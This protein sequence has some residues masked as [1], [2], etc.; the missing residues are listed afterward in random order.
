MEYDA[1]RVGTTYGDVVGFELIGAPQ[2]SPSNT[3]YEGVSLTISQNAGIN[4]GAV[5]MSFQW[6]SN[7][8]PIVDATNST[9]VFANPTPDYTANYSVTVSNFYGGPVTSPE[10]LITVLPGVKPFFVQ[11]PQPLSL[12]RYVGA[13]S[14]QLTV[15]A[16]GTPPFTYQ[17]QHAGT[18]IQSATTTAD[19]SNTLTISPITLA[20]AGNY[21]VTITNAYGSTNSTLAALNLIVP[22]VGSYAA[23]LLSL[24][25]NPTNLF[26]YWRMD[27]NATTNDPTLNEYWNGN[28]GMMSIQDLYN[29]RITP[30]EAAAPYIGFPSPHLGTALGTHGE[31]WDKPY[32]VDLKNLPSAQTNMTFTMWVKGGVRL[33]ARAGYGQA[34]GLENNGTSVRVLWGAY[35][36]TNGVKTATWDTGLTA[37]ADDWSFVALVVKGNDVTV[38][39]GGTNSFTSVS[40]ADINGIPDL[41]N[42]GFMTLVNS[43]AIGDSNLRLGVGRTPVPWADDGNGAPWTSAGGTWSDIAVFYQVLTAEQIKGLYLAGGAGRWLE[44]IPDGSGNLTLN[45]TSGF[46]LQEAAAVT[47]PWTD[48]VDATPPYSAPITT[49]GAKFYRV[50][51]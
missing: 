1:I 6:L 12:N 17:W 41:E 27:D 33:A 4:S 24:P 18:N 38:Y 25:T 7:G 31:L 43:T 2:G 19:V 36:S 37:S 8:V 30:G 3:V 22:A 14:A 45:W 39:V 10:T 9:L 51:P 44:G 21:S 48:I 23:A 49:T 26:G 28:S 34:Y 15:V 50:K 46:T 35:D 42:G 16:N 11:Q 47:G 40:S 20:D 5:P 29:G 13:P 32:R